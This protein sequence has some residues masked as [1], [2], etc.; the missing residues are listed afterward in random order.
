L[1][2]LAAG[3]LAGWLGGVV[4]VVATQDEMNG[5]DEVVGDEN[6]GG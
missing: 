1:A 3:W 2:E 6:L 5:M 4:D